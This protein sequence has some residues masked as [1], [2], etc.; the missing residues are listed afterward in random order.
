MSQRYVYILCVLLKYPMTV[1]RKEKIK[2]ESA[3]D[4]AGCF[5]SFLSGQTSSKCETVFPKIPVKF[6]LQRFWCHCET[7]VEGLH[8][9][10]TCSPAYTMLF[11]FAN[12]YMYIQATFTEKYLHRCRLTCS[13]LPLLGMAV[14]VASH[15]NNVSDP[16][17][18]IV[19]WPEYVEWYNN[20]LAVY[21]LNIMLHLWYRTSNIKPTLVAEWLKLHNITWRLQKWCHIRVKTFF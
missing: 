8:L 14:C 21:L 1:L 10:H 11:Q 18:S 4:E 5:S 13:Q 15:I 7:C 3:S 6:G 16:S 20:P 2:R 9:L 19:C 17:H 12:L